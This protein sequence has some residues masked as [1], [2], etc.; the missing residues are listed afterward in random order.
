MSAE[1]DLYT[2]LSGASGVTDIVSTRIYSDVRDQ[3]TDVPALT[4]SRSG[5]N[6]IQ[7]L[8]TGEV[9]AEQATLTVACL[10]KTRERAEALADQVYLASIATALAYQDRSGDYDPDT[11]LFITTIVLIHNKGN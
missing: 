10:A 11:D 6:I 9:F 5:T 2:A 1:S 4:Y 7:S 8:H 3:E